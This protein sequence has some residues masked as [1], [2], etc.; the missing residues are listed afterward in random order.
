MTE[1]AD[2]STKITKGAYVVIFLYGWFAVTIFTFYTEFFILQIAE[3]SGEQITNDWFEV[4]LMIIAFTVIGLI[5]I[6][7]RTASYRIE[8][9]LFTDNGVT[10]WKAATAII[11]LFVLMFLSLI[12]LLS[13]IAFILGT[14]FS[15]GMLSQPEMDID[16]SIMLLFFFILGVTFVT[17]A[18]SEALKL[19]D[20]YLLPDSKTEI[21]SQKIDEIYDLLITKNTGQAMQVNVSPSD[22]EA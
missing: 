17:L 21:D 20:K 16:E 11:M 9:A 8:E 13:V 5:M 18:I 4:S 6:R 1:N 12:I 2:E 7:Y 19:L 14:G 3:W 22:E 15:L 10:F